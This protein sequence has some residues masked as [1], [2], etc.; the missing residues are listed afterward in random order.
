MFYRHFIPAS[1]SFFCSSPKSWGLKNHGKGKQGETGNFSARL[2]EPKIQHSM[3]EE[4]A[5]RDDNSAISVESTR[6]SSV[7]AARAFAS[8]RETGAKF[9]L[10]HE[11][12]TASTTPTMHFQ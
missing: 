11:R 6:E 12:P 10:G 4:R 9:H 3:E 8:E 7:R 1:A 5:T 2:G